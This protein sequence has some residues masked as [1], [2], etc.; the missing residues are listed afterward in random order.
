MQH[1][2]AIWLSFRRVQHF[3]LSNLKWQIHSGRKVLLGIDSF[4]GFRGSS[5]VPSSILFHLHRAGLFS[6][7]RVIKDW[8]GS[9]PVLMDAPDVG[10]PPDLFPHWD[11]LK[12]SLLQGGFACSAD[13]DHLVWSLSPSSSHAIVKDIYMHLI[14]LS[15]RMISKRFPALWWNLGCPL[16]VTLFTWL[17]FSNKNLTWESLRKR[18][19]HGPSRCAL[20]KLDEETNF[21]LFFKCPVSQQIWSELAQL[22]SFP[23]LSFISVEAA[24][25]WWGRQIASLRPIL[26]IA[27]WSLWKWR[28]NF[29][30]KT[31]PSPPY[32]SCLFSPLSFLH[33]H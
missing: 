7:D 24:F 33:D 12:T 17:V 1:G 10:I 20:C 14:A 23:H 28:N 32:M 30:F 5:S 26:P 8:N 2:S 11:F 21:H 31:H 13:D 18:S 16:K 29:F 9:S 4:A 15:N 22:F 6:W 25:A 27:L 3:F 19:W